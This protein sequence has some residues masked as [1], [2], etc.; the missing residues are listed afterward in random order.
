MHLKISWTIG[1]GLV[2][3]AAVTTPWAAADAAGGDVAAM[4]SSKIADPGAYLFEGYPLSVRFA[5]VPGVR[6]L[7]GRM[8]ARPLP[9]GGE[10]VL[11]TGERV[12]AQQLLGQFELIEH[13]WVADHYIFRLPEGRT[14]IEVAAELLST[15]LFAW[16]EPDYRVYPLACPNDPQFSLQ[17]HHEADRMNSC[18]GWDLFTGDPRVSVAICDTG[19][20]LDH[21][22]LQMHRLEGYNAETRVWESQG[23]NIADINGHGTA[24]SGCAA[25]NGNNGIGISGVG[26]NLSHRT[27]R[28][29]NSPGG[30]AFI[31]TLTHAALTAVEN[32]DK[33]AS[34]SYGGVDTLQARD[35]ATVIK[36]LGGL[37]VWA[38]GNE[39]QLL[40][41]PNRDDD[42]L[43]VVAATD[44]N[45]RKASFSNFGTII[46]VAAPGV[47][48]FTTYAGGPTFYVT[49][50]GTSFSCPLTAGLAALIWSFDPSLTPDQ[51]EQI[52]KTGA[53]DL[54]DPGA[55]NAF[56]YGRINVFKS[57][58]Q[59]S[60]DPIKWQFP[61]GLPEQ[62][63]PEVETV[64]P[65]EIIPIASDPLP[66][67]ATMW[68]S[69]GGNYSP[70][71]LS[72]LGGDEY[73]AVIP[74]LACS[75]DVEF[76][77]SVM[78]DNAG[79]I[80]DP[81]DAP[82]TVHDALATNGTPVAFTDNFQAGGTGWSATFRNLAAGAWERGKPINVGRGDPPTDFDGSGAC[83][84]TDNTAVNSDVDGGPAVLTSP[85][86]ALN[87]NDAF[88]SFAVWMFSD[89]GVRD[90][91]VIEV[92]N[93]QGQTWVPVMN[94]SH[95]GR[96]WTPVSFRVS[97][98][99]APAAAV[100]VR[101]AVAD[102][103]NDSLTEAGI[104]AFEVKLI[105]CLDAEPLALSVPQLVS[106][107]PAVLVATGCTP[108][109]KAHFVYTGVGT[110]STWAGAIGTYLDLRAPELIGSRIAGSDGEASIEK[111]IPVTAGG[112]RVWLQAAQIGRTSNVEQRTIQ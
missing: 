4:A 27:M 44:Q 93:D 57:L 34:V 16:V 54:G 35:T 37:L 66:A 101:M 45:D 90:E 63:T 10:A 19:I 56:G 22:D 15:G 74:P 100:Q 5:P 11:P 24:C 89:A 82:A 67:T 61:A 41:G 104:D 87:G 31:S 106:G 14:E 47:R 60:P 68:Y 71:A 28:V 84:V 70:V 39:N 26:W 21:V 32:G 108:N 86:V 78:T 20:Q 46:D 109:E 52:I 83:Y 6:E 53:D 105:Q 80:R 85:L 65:V 7:S 38:A 99:V 23:G 81:L 73:E 69:T 112:K 42:D 59:V 40:I 9:G 92:S 33:V 88:I 36:G 8:I 102:D 49:I 2:F 51:V 97:D 13:V 17:W 3:G 94:M 76:Y 72:H 62:I 30:G 98:Y 91:M 95:M 48:I 25:G 77:F 43:I 58:Q 12:T 55:D 110:G 50:D 1:L 103:P 29:S 18:L 96:V 64:I 75:T 111:R 107:Q 79:E